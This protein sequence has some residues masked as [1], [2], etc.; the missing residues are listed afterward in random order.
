MLVKIKKNNQTL[1]TSDCIPCWEAG[2]LVFVADN[3]KAVCNDLLHIS[4]RMEVV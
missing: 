3:Y 1:A 2:T 4:H